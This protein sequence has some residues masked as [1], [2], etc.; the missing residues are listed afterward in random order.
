LVLFFRVF[1]EKLDYQSSWHLAILPIKD[2]LS[3]SFN[4]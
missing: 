2:T 1:G 4:A 3:S